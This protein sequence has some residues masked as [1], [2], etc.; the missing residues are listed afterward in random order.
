MLVFAIL[1]TLNLKQSL[2]YMVDQSAPI[3]M[4]YFYCL[5]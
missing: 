5:E 1:L 3:E 2:L 4:L